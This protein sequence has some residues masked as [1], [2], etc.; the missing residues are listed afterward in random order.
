MPPRGGMADLTDLELRA[1][2]L[3]MFNPAGMTVEAA[4]AAPIAPRD[5]NRRISDGMEIYLGI[6]SAETMRE[7]YGAG[8]PERALHGGIPS[9]HDYYH[10]NISLFDA[11]TRLAIKNADV[12]V[13]VSDPVS[14][15]ETKKLERVTVKGV[16]SYGD[17]FRM[18]GKNPYRIVVRIQKPGAPREIRAE[19]QFKPS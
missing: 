4:K 11:K 7:R 17:Y 3:Y 10:L 2:V 12:E 9:G 14:G 19:F 8:D 18:T 16:T 1:A 15:A 5:P 13:S 6:V